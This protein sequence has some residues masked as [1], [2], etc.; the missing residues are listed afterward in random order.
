M[1]V[2]TMKKRTII[3]LCCFGLVFT[4]LLG[5]TSQ[6]L[7]VNSLADGIRVKGFYMEPENSLDMVTI[8]A[9]ETYTSI[10]PGILWKEYGFTSYNYSVAGCPVSVVKSQVKE[11]LSRQK[12][13]VLVIEVNGA[14][15]ENGAYQT[16]DKRLRKYIDNMP[17][18]ENKIETIK[19]VVPEEEQEYYFFPFLKYHSNWK[20]LHIC[21][22]NLYFQAKMMLNGG[23]RL[24]GFQTVSKK[25]E[26]KKELV[27]I[28]NDHSTTPLAKEAEYYLRDLLQYLKD[29]HIE[30]VVFIRIPHRI[31]EKGYGDFQR[32]NRVGEI[33][34]EY[35]FPYVNFEMEREAI[36]LNPEEDFYNDSHMNLYG[37]EK[38]TRYLGEYLVTHYDLQHS[39]HGEETKKAWD[40]SAK[41]TEACR[42]YGKKKLEEGKKRTINESWREN[43]KYKLEL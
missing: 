26:I 6:F 22:A 8:G 41:E 38:F 14:V 32:S 21:A 1:E 25:A 39:M 12:P 9:S 18:S 7:Q 27:D 37:Q 34:K 30:N 33:V 15:P 11:V 36:A 24:K 28:T 3:K 16:Q 4:L 13:K 17:W 20:N 29:E 23:S 43:E 31:T 40:E 19:E 42:A 35:G 10:A 5:I 2:H